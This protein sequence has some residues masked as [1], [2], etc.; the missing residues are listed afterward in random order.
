MSIGPVLGSILLA[1]AAALALAWPALRRPRAR[2]RASFDLA[3]YRD[4]L[5]EIERD[6]RRGLIGAGEAAAARL[7]VERRILRAADAAAAE[8]G[9]ARH[10]RWPALAAAVAVPLLAAVLYLQ[11]GTPGLRD[12]PLAARQPPADQPDIAGMVARLEE[13]LQR[14]PDDLRGW[15]MLGRS[16]TVM[17]RPDAAV[18]AYRRALALAPGEPEAIGGLA[19]GLIVTAGGLV[20]PEALGLLQRLDGLVPGEPRV[21][22][23]LGLA[24]AQAGDTQAAVE[25]W[26]RLLA[27]APADAPWRA[28][29]VEVI[30][31]A[32][33]QLGIEVEPM[34]AAT[35]GSAADPAAV[36]AAAIASLPAEQ[37]QARIREMVDGLQARM[38]ADGGDAAGWSRLAQARGV[39]GE[40][41]AA[42]AAWDRA[43]ALA[44]GDPVLLKGKAGALLGPD[45]DGLPQVGD[46]AAALY[47]KAAG[48]RPDDPE[49]LWFLGL[50]ALQQGQPELARQRWDRLLAQLDPGRG[51]TVELRARIDRLLSPPQQR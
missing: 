44:P 19:E 6:R 14:E 36:E 48:L 47:E 39:L 35:P 49:S 12:Q 32:A 21:G 29:M 28:R 24:A 8:T 22:Y 10:S 45:A 26:R 38:E 3:V 23:Y 31:G 25:R 30:S 1:L 5:A 51:E 13:R 50:R 7:E 17:G 40:Q 37:R 41:D 4:Q 2:N 18:L 42:L 46:E 15:L 34:L 16:R 20:G 33:S 11:L 9:E 27:D 43:L